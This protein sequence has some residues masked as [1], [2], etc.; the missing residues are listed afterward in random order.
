MERLT[1]I[2]LFVGILLMFIPIIASANPQDTLS[3]TIITNNAVAR[4]SNSG[5]TKY[6]NVQDG[7]NVRT[8]DTIYGIYLTDTSTST[9]YTSPSVATYHVVKVSNEGNST[10]TVLLS[11]NGFAYGGTSGSAWSGIFYADDGA[12]GGTSQDG[13]H[14]AG[15]TTV[16]SSLSLGEDAATYFFFAVTPA[17]D[18]QDNSV[19]SNTVVNTIS[20][21]AGF[22]TYTS[23][24]G[25]N[26]LVYAGPT[27]G[28]RL[29]V[30]IVQGPNIQIAK[31]SFVTNTA[32]Y[33]ALGGGGN[34]F[35][36]GAEVTFAITWTNSG[37]GIAY[38]LTFSDDLN[39]NL[40][41]KTNSLKY[42][43]NAQ[44]TPAPADYAAAAALSDANDNQDLGAYQADGHTNAGGQVRFDYAANISGGARGT[45]FFKAIVK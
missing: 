15:E 31:T 32:S 17:A 16:I 9:L 23:Y 33:I 5:G 7:T 6:S 4:Y 8:V 41:Y 20:N 25:F 21:Y 12:G 27:N 28:S 37:S 3:G 36:P 43:D 18:A 30:T 44:Q 13:I 26:G 14:Q 29:T 45:L 1:K 35:T 39:S 34:D 19:G 10:I 22:S 2:L 38:G 42:V 24:T 40:E 11:T